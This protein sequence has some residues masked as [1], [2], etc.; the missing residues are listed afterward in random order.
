MSSPIEVFYGSRYCNLTFSCI[1]SANIEDGKLSC[2]GRIEIKVDDSNAEL[3]I[4]MDR[5]ENFISYDIVKTMLGYGKSGN[6]L[7]KSDNNYEVIKFILENFDGGSFEEKLTMIYATAK[8]FGDFFQLIDSYYLNACQL[9]TDLGMLISA[10][11]LKK[12]TLTNIQDIVLDHNII[13]GTIKDAYQE[14]GGFEPAPVTVVRC[15]SLSGGRSPLYIR[16]AAENTPDIK[17]SELKLQDYIIHYKKNKNENSFDLNSTMLSEEDITPGTDEH[18]GFIQ[19]KLNLDNISQALIV[20]LQ[21]MKNRTFV[22]NHVPNF[23]SPDAIKSITL[24]TYNWFELF[25]HNG[26]NLLM[27]CIFNEFNELLNDADAAGYME[28]KRNGSGGGGQP[29]S[30]PSTLFDEYLE[31]IKNLEG[32]KF[33][34]KELPPRHGKESQYISDFQNAHTRSFCGK[35]F[36]RIVNYVFDR[37]KRLFGTDSTKKTVRLFNTDIKRTDVISYLKPLFT[38]FFGANAVIREQ[39]ER[40]Q[41]YN[42]RK[43]KFIEHL[44]EVKMFYD[45]MLKKYFD[46]DGYPNLC[47]VIQDDSNFNLTELNRLIQNQIKLEQDRKAAAN[48]NASASAYEKNLMRFEGLIDEIHRKQTEKEANYVQATANNMDFNPT[49]TLSSSHYHIPQV[50]NLETRFGS[51]E[52]EEKKK[53]ETTLGRAST[54]QGQNLPPIGIRSLEAKA[55]KKNNPRSVKSGPVHTGRERMKGTRKKLDPLI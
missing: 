27:Y 3:R 15:T 18:L 14:P 11:K 4:N 46:I 28:V 40:E 13:R 55:A 33:P 36:N 35:A 26:G 19:E 24:K 38:D 53:N 45:D 2:T 50:R 30:T 20:F 42:H 51:S 16:Q 9:T 31:C 49:D 37:L 44:K 21:F 54:Y 23:F 47:K 6:T 8:P 1:I 12:K 41:Y 43:Q 34:K 5:Y 48:A 29:P 39:T 25:E 52:E 17:Y 7:S 32:I 22:I 10:S